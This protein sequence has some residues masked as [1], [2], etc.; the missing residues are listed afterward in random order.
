MSLGKTFTNSIVREIG[1]NY[2]KSISNSIMGDKHSTPIRVTGSRGGSSGSSR[3]VKSKIDKA[4]DKFEIKG[5]KAT[6]GAGLNIHME[7]F[8]LV[9]E[10]QADGVIDLL[11]LNQLIEYAPKVSGIISRAKTAL[12]DLSAP[13]ESAKLEEKLEDIRDFLKALYESLDTKELSLKKKPFAW[14]FGILS[15]AGLDRVY[16]QPKKISSYVIAFFFPALIVL[17]VG[18]EGKGDDMTFY[19]SDSPILLIIAGIG[20]LIPFWYGI[21]INP[22]TKGGYR[23]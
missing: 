20:T 9:D 15:L 1:R 5:A 22:I 16:F 7:Y 23:S 19:G 3:T 18:N 6:L 10:A 14:V 11:E 4:L 2:G 17:L 8:N 13:V 21:I 12:D